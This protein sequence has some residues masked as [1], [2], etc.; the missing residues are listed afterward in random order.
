VFILVDTVSRGGNLLLDIGPRGDG[1]IPVIM[2]QRLKEI[3]DWMRI[4]G[5]AIYGTEP[6][7]N[8]R[9]WTAGEVPK[10]EYNKEFSSAYDVTELI[11]N[12]ASGRATIEAFFTAKGNDVYAILPHWSGHSFVLQ[13]LNVAKSVTLLGLPTPLK[14]TATGSGLAIALPDLPENLRTQP[15]WVLKISQ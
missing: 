11:D 14:F 2:E 1:T 7:K 9:Q 13:K 5:E 3:G 12:S 6:W 10:I 8:T 15:A 4:N